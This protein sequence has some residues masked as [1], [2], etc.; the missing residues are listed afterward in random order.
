MSTPSSHLPLGTLIDDDSLELVEVLGV[1]GYG[2][3]YRAEDVCSPSPMSYAVKCL[4]HNHSTQSMRQRQAHMREIALHQIAG[5]HP[6]VVTL[7]R[8]VEDYNFTYIIMDYAPDHDL[9]SQILHKSRYLGDD[10]LIKHIFLQMVDAVEYCHQLGIYHRDLKPENIL[11]FD[12]G[13]RIAITDFGLATT[14][15][16]SEE[17]RTGSIYHMSPGKPFTFHLALQRLIDASLPSECQ[18]GDFGVAGPYS[19]MFNDIWS[20]GIILLNLATGRNPWKSASASDPTFQAYLRDPLGFLPTV[21]PISQELNDVLVRMLEIDWRER[22]TIAELRQA[23]EEVDTFYS[24]GVILEGSMA[25][26]PWEAGMD[27]DSDSSTKQ[28]VHKSE[29]HPSELKSCWSQ[30]S[31]V[32]SDMVFAHHSPDEDSFRHSPW[33]AYHP[34]VVSYSDSGDSYARHTQMDEESCDFYAMHPPHSLTSPS[35]SESTSFPITP[36]AYETSFGGRATRKPLMIDTNCGRPGYYKGSLEPISATS[37]SI[38]KTAVEFIDS[39]LLLSSAM[40]QTVIVPRSVHLGDSYSAD[41]RE[42]ASPTIWGTSSVS[43]VSSSSFYSSL[44]SESFT[45]THISFDHRSSAPS[46]ESFS[47]SGFSS[48]SDPQLHHHYHHHSTSPSHSQPP[49][50]LYLPNPL[51]DNIPPRPLSP[52]KKFMAE[53]HRIKNTL[54]TPLK[55][56]PRFS[57]SSP[58]TPTTTIAARSTNPEKGATASASQVRVSW[59][60]FTPPSSNAIQGTF[61]SPTSSLVEVPLAAGRV[62][63]DDGERGYRARGVEVAAAPF[64]ADASPH[65]KAPGSFLV[66][67]SPMRGALCDA[68]T[69]AAARDQATSATATTACRRAADYIRSPRYWFLPTKLWASHAAS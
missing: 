28:S 2:I 40:D 33:G 23:I 22:M 14:D 56:F 19:P 49:F 11:C 41:D 4:P 63:D 25:R 35:T 9:F 29:S 62:D 64:R 36:N 17:Y 67:S 24:E 53:T 16:L 57:A 58:P 26:C 10:Y 15:K 61:L 27:I 44:Q 68:K 46:P 42:M 3:V 50:P 13:L 1:G 31:A 20:L 69:A 52:T 34:R 47:L 65:V 30:D 32:S 21:L 51:I 5:A 37:S 6:N 54:F 59:P 66:T 60:P 12:D 55:F 39:P 8:V 7:H 38:M 48:H 45:T 43:N 18:G